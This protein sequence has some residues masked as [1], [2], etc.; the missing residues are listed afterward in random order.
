MREIDDE[1]EATKDCARCGGRAFFW[2]T[3]VVAGS[4]QAPSWRTHA[5]AHQQPAWTCMTCGYIEPHERRT[6]QD[7]RP[8]PE[9]R[10]L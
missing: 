2:R 3:A 8:A 1:A 5:A 6:R 10:L 9:Q 4:P 7:A